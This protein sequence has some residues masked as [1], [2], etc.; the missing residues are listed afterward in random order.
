MILPI[1]LRGAYIEQMTDDEFFKFGWHYHSLK[2]DRT[3]HSRGVG[4]DT[5]L[6]G[7]LILPDFE[8]E[9]ANCGFNDMHANGT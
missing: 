4:C 6:C 1:T 9:L 5:N 8:I 3:T 7:G 2:F